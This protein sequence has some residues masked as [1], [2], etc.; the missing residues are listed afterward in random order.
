MAANYEAFKNYDLG[1]EQLMYK[2]STALQNCNFTIKQIDSDRGIFKAKTSFS[3]WSWKEVIDI[4]VT[5]NGTLY[6][7]SECSMP[8]QMYSWG[9]N[10][11]NVAKLFSQIDQLTS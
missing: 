7:K 3:I 8:A 1:K 10:K 6:I 11:K 2:I 5:D 9:K 4:S